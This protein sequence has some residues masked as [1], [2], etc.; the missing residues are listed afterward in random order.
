MEKLIKV[1]QTVAKNKVI[2]FLFSRYATYFIHFINSLFIA[3]YLGPYYLGIWGF[4]SLITQYV[5]QINFGIAHSVTALI[6]VHKKKEFYVQKIIGTSLTMLLGLSLV[7]VL[8]FIANAVFNLQLGAKYNFS[9]YAPIVV[10]IGILGYFNSLFSSVFRVYGRLFEIAFNQ[11]VFPLLI[12]ASILFF[13]KDELLWALVGANFLAFLVSFVLYVSRSP[14]SL[15][16]TFIFSLFKT[17]QK[18]GWHL[19]VYNS[20]FYFIIISTRSFVSGFYSVEE[21]GYFTFAFSLANVVLMVLQAFSFLIFP[22][23]LNRFASATADQNNA[24]LKKLRDAYVTTSH[25]LVHIA[26]LLF[27]LFL[28]VFPQYSSVSEAFV[29]IALAVVLYSNSFGYSGLLIAKGH[30]KRLSRLSL[31]ALII[32]II[33]AFVLIRVFHVP[34]AMVIIATMI[35][36]FIYVFMLGVMGRKMLGLPTSLVSVV[37]DIY[38]LRLLIP[39]VTTLGLLFFSVPEYYYILSLILFVVLNFKVLSKL[40][41]L[42]KS[43]ISNPNFINI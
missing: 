28:V 5:N 11:T 31:L 21:F 42:M 40:K 34:F 24:L 35:S 36:Y 2:L 26:I 9:T 20:S 32:N 29:L 33:T 12:L 4:I 15:K 38:P 14:V 10:L 19:F 25:L 6:S 27:P 37:K 3:V 1:V 18:K 41:T 13:K 43:I 39:Y 16:P 22:K 8:F 7:V 30:E 17:I 23:L